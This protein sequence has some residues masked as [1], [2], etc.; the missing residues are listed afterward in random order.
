MAGGKGLRLR[1]LTLNTPKPLLK[2][3]NLPLI[4]Y[5]INNILKFGVKN[6]WISVGYLGQLI[7]DYIGSK[8]NIASF[9]FVTEV[10][11]LG[12]I[13]A[14]SKIKDFKN[15][16]VL[17][18]NADLITD[19]DLE[20]FYLEHINKDSDITILVKNYDVKVPFGIVDTNHSGAITRILEKPTFNYLINGGIYLINKEH[21]S[22]IPKGKFYN[23]TDLIEL[24]IELGLKINY[25]KYSGIW[26]DLGL[27]DDF[28]KLNNK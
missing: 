23:A 14:L 2:V 6:F 3:N 16:I 8:K 27:I 28:R 4:D 22:L 5:G 12:T 21:L 24:M 15:D 1:P 25:F 19:F 13:G 17:I 26:H 9:N 20:E 7:K 10:T 11:P 18:T